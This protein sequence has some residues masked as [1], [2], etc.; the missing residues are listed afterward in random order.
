MYSSLRAKAWSIAL[1]LALFGVAAVCGC[2]DETSS[3]AP[4]GGAGT[5]SGGS[6]GAGGTA[7]G[8]N[9]S[10]GVPDPPP[11][12]PAG[13]APASPTGTV[14]WV[15]TDGD[16]QTGDGSEATPWATITQALDNAPDGATILVKPGTYD[17]RVRL[18]GTFA[19]GVTVRSEVPYQARLRHTDTVVT[20]YTNP[21]GV[22][23]I[24]LEGLDIAHSGPGAGALV[25]HLDGDGNEA[26]TG[27]TLRNNVLHDS[28]NNDI[29]KIN[30]GIA[31][32]TVERNLFFNQS[33]ADEHIDINSARDILVQDNIFMNDFAASGRSNDSDTSS[34]IVVKDSNGDTD[35][36]T[37]SHQIIIR[38]NIFLNYQGSTGTGFLLLGE[39]GK[40]FHESYQ[41]L[42]ENNLMLGNADNLMRAPFGVKGG[43]DVVFRSNTVV[44][45]M[46]ARAFAMRL[47]TEGANPPNDNI[48]FYDNIWSDPTGTMGAIDPNDTN[49]FSDTDPAQTTSFALDHNLYFNGGAAIPE[50]A[51]ELINPSDDANSV[52]GDPK[53]GDQAGLVAPHFD[54]TA[55]SFADGSATIC[56]AFAALVESYCALGDG[57]AAIDAALADESA[58][59]DIVGTTRGAAPD[60]G[61]CEK[62]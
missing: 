37:G 4:G 42:I 27:I 6:A 38:R 43:R 59:D 26:V 15:A 40:P 44:G 34:Y 17:G 16:D 28:Y 33:G 57:S 21:S 8:G 50:D 11:T 48:S 58:S 30:N 39:D 61:A 22:A 41:V 51:A 10:G 19:Q 9:G 12:P 55:G 52:V 1:W 24:T 47:N 32:I 2:G 62:P 7:A 25:V 29:L 36:Y 3:G 53:L 35:I 45:D 56:E 31:G 5:S 13:C 14:L 23:G 60:L 46:P 54:S 49:D 18:R 20:A